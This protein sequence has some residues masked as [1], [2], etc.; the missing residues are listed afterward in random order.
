MCNGTV[1]QRW[2]VDA[3]NELKEHGH[4]LVLLIR[5]ARKT[6]ETSRFRQL[7]KKKWNTFLYT[8]LE[9]RVFKPDARRMSDIH[10][11]LQG[12]DILDC[13]V[14]QKGYSEYFTQADIKAV[15]SYQLDFILRFG[16]NIIRGDILAAARCGV[17]S[18]H[19][20]DEIKYRGGPAGFW[21]IFN[22]DPVNGAILQQL[23]HKLD[24]GFILKKG[25]LKTIMHSYRGNLEQ[26]LSVT[27]SW[28]ALVADAMVSNPG[29]VFAASHTTAPIYKVPGN[30]LMARFLFKLFLNRVKFHSNDLLSAEDWNVGLIMKPIHEVALGI[31]ILKKTEIA[32]IR[33]GSRNKYLADPSG[34][35]ENNKLHILAE[36]YSYPKK[37]AII[38]EIVWDIDPVRVF[39]PVRVSD[40]VRV[41]EAEDHLSYPFV[42]KHQGQV[43]C[44]PESYQSGKITLYR[45]DPATGTFVKEKILV[46][47]MEAV[48]PTLYFYNSSWW[49]FFTIKKYS[50][51]HLFIY[52]A[53]EITGE[54]MP[55]CCN[56]MKIDVRSA[57]PAGTPF[58]HNGLLYRPAQDCSVTYGGRVVIN[59]VVKLD[60]HEFEEQPVKSVG[61][62]ADTKYNR[63]LH[64]ISGIN[65][66]TLIDGK[67]YRFNPFFFRNQLRKKLIKN[68]F[69]KCLKKYWGPSAPG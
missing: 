19:H 37:K 5:D 63:G 6:S 45:R 24:G 23:T 1:F 38:S 61:P 17:W 31:G 40:P 22:G 32:W 39:D 4:S 69:G 64:T 3:L 42:I 14:E 35:I 50:A 58:I 33:R 34:F 67:R 44:L 36:E 21:E 49:L 26:L 52:H 47:N 29:V 9:N 48:D 57:R 2:Q 53:A 13:C 62:V 65:E 27:S 60:E 66:F 28:P 56:P 55:H 10:R 43:Y 54:Y 15:G 30:W 59:H 7:L 25:Y 20:D 8:F 68:G 51:T 16:F 41:I 18:F 11:K 46:D 12:I